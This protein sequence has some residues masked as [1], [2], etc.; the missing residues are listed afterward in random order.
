VQDFNANY[1]FSRVLLTTVLV[2]TVA[3]T[4]AN[5][6]DLKYYLVLMPAIPYEIIH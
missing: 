6:N 2:I 1:A 3:L 4:V 5:Y